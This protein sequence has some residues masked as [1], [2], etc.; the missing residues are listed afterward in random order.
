M[1][2][3]IWIC[4]GLLIMT[5]LISGCA[6]SPPSQPRDAPAPAGTSQQTAAP[7]APPLSVIGTNW[8]LGWYDDT[9]G[10]WSKVIDGSTITATFGSTQILSGSGGCTQYTTE[11]KLLEARKIW[12]RRPAVS[13]TNCPAPTGVMH[14]QSTYYTDL[15]L[16]ET[17]KIENGQ[18][19][20]FDRTNKKILQF[21]PVS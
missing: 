4:I 10:V 14:Q 2:Y 20:M 19:L 8:K 1:R 17:Y 16:S 5:A 13:E 15:E 9:R 12:I 7:A 11:Y 21:D 6:T 3:I 18:L